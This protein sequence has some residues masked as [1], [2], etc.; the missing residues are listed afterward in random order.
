MRTILSFVKKNVYYFLLALCLIAIATII[1]VGTAQNNRQQSSVDDTHVSN[2]N[3]D[4]NEN[5]NNNNNNNKPSEDEQPTVIIFDVPI[6]T[7]TIGMDYS[8]SEAVFNQTMKRNEMHLGVDFLAENGE[9]VYVAYDGVV[10]STSY[11]V[12][13]GGTVVVEHDN[14]VSSVYKS[15]DENL[16][17]KVGDRLRKGDII[18]TVGASLFEV[19]EGSHLHFELLK[20]GEKISPYDY[21]LE[22]EK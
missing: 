10:A 7:G 4:D 2:G 8:N 11:D 13:F 5:N 16:N 19:L 9:N 18:G 21:F 1:V 22:G 12:L 3:L 17:V 15:L 6:K 20:D 14:G